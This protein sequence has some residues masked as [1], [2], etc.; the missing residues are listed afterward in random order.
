MSDLGKLFGVVS[1]YH[2]LAVHNALGSLKIGRGMPHVLDY[3]SANSGCK[4]S[5]IS[6]LGHVSPA[7]TTVM[8]QSMEKNGF[9]TRAADEKDQR[10]IR[11]YITDS[12]RE[13]AMR[14]KESAEKAD[15]AFFSCLNEEECDILR[16][17]LFKL[18]EQFEIE[19]EKSV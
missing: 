6:R 7:T 15:E 10:C 13:T 9:I 5:E 18:K 11:L 8:L 2:G 1:R 14:G 19:R 12:G 16:E 3:I 4:Q 17:I